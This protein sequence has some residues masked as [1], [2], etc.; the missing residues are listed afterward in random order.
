MNRDPGE[1]LDDCVM[2]VEFVTKGILSCH[3]ETEHNFTAY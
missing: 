2:G 1:E 3:A